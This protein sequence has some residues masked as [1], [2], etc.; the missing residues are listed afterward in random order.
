MKAFELVFDLVLQGLRQGLLI[1]T[2]ERVLDGADGDLRARSDFLGKGADFI[3]K[4]VEGEN[5]VQEAE[6]VSGL[7]INHFTGIKHLGRDGRANELGKK[8]G[9]PIVGKQADIGEILAKN[10]F[11]SGDTNIGSEGKIHSRARGRTIHRGDDRLR[12]G[13]DLQDGLH[14]GTE[15]RAEFGGVVAIAALADFAEIAAGTKSAAGTGKNH[16]VDGVIVGNASE[17]VIESIRK[18]FVEGV[19]TCGTIHHQSGD[20][21]LPVFEEDGR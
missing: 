10:G 18:I 1:A 5:V 21:P 3:L 6:A 8:K 13:A 17:R 7:G 2:E 11:F 15:Y 4:T 16:D 19:E 20:G 9:S 12:H 14:P